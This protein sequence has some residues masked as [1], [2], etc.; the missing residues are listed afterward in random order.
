MLTGLCLKDDNMEILS[1]PICLNLP[2]ERMIRFFWR[3]F[4]K[5]LP[6]QVCLD[7]PGSLIVCGDSIKV[8]LPEGSGRKVVEKIGEGR[9][10]WAVVFCSHNHKPAQNC[11]ILVTSNIRL[12][13]AFLDNFVRVQHPLWGLTLV[14]LQGS[15][16]TFNRP[17]SCSFCTTRRDQNHD[18]TDH[19][20]KRL[21][22]QGSVNFEGVEQGWSSSFLLQLLGHHPDQRDNLSDPHDV[23]DHHT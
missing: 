3:S 21:C 15:W 20:M 14:L 8:N 6:M 13:L 16:Y 9:W 2:L 19:K 22:K 4:V 18:E 17:K 1:T 7:L 5:I 10:Q 12:P 23:N 11:T